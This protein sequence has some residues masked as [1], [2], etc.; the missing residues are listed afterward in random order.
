MRAQALVRFIIDFFYFNLA[1]CLFIALHYHRHT[2]NVV[3]LLTISDI[4][5]STCWNEATLSVS[6]FS[7]SDID[8]FGVHILLTQFRLR[9]M[10]V[11][12]CVFHWIFSNKTAHNQSFRILIEICPNSVHFV[13]G[14][15]VNCIRILMCSASAIS[16]WITWPMTNYDFHVYWLLQTLSLVHTPSFIQRDKKWRRLFFYLFIL[17]FHR[18]IFYVLHKCTYLI[19]IETSPWSPR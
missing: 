4:N 5:L 14:M 6:P 3:V 13:F 8:G 1:S 19:C 2:S 9:E 12:V 10:F 7:V 11:C 17:L 15:H 18:E 16:I